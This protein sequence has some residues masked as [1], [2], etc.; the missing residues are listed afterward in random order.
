MRQLQAKPIYPGVMHVVPDP[1]PT[2]LVSISHIVAGAIK[3][4]EFLVSAT[5]EIFGT[6][7]MPGTGTPSGTIKSKVTLAGHWCSPALS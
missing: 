7:T 3:E 4:E 6:Y 2:L 5:H 1:F